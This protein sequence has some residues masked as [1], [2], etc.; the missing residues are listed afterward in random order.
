MKLLILGG[1][2]FLGRALVDAALDAGHELTLFNRGQSNPDLYPQVEQIR[3]SR[4]GGLAG[5]H[6]RQ[7]DAVIDTCGYVPRLV[8]DSARLLADAVGHYTFISSI[9]VYRDFAAP[10][11]TEDS[12]L[13]TMA[14]ETVEEITGE[15]YG[16]LKVLCEQTISEAMN[17]RALHVRAGLIVGPHDPTDRFSYWPYRIAQGG[18]VLAPGNPDA[19]VQFI[20]VRDLAAWTVQATAQT[21]RGPFNAT[22]PDHRLSMRATLETCRQALGSDASFVWVDEPFLLAH[23]VAPWTDLPLWVTSDESE[24]FGT[25]NC[26]NAQQAGLV[27]RPLAQTAQDTLA[28]LNTRPADYVWRNGLTAVRETELLALWESGL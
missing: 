17:G 7:W 4:D 1:T 20:D 24:G 10:G 11:I 6:G 28:W 19:P 9:S 15:T 27:Y 22:G 14:D 21:L 18:R 3:G 13:A 8:G 26:G 25:V 12:P 23:D 2:R 5:L 16:P